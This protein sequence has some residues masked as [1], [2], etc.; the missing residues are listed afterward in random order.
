MQPE[1]NRLSN[2]L[3]ASRQLGLALTAHQGIQL[4]GHLDLLVKWNKTYNLTAIRDPA[5]MV[6]QHLLDSLAVVPALRRS[7][8]K[9]SPRILDVGSGAGFPGLTL[10]AA[11]PDSQIICVDSVGKKIGFI[12]QVIA[13]LGLANAKAEHSRIENLP[14]VDADV[15][16]SR[17]FAS[18]REFT[19]LTRQHLASDGVWMAMKGKVPDEE[20]ADLELSTQVFH[21]EQL[22]VP[23]L[24]SERCLV[25]MRPT[26][27]S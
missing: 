9:A 19:A 21:V 20:I 26:L 23:G 27:A 22:S 24:E 10:A 18:L 1:E 8:T 4:I 6:L 7:T 17:A 12:R 2:L 15:I 11:M 5:E 25:W 3:E 14:N 13:E 16:T